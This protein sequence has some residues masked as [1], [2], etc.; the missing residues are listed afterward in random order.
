MA[1]L[2]LN[3]QD[4]EKSRLLALGEKNVRFIAAKSLTQTAQQIQA[5]VKQHL[6]ETF[7][8]RKPNFEKS[9]KIR[10]ATKQNLTAETY[11]MAGFATLQQTGGHRY[12]KNGRL[13]VPKYTDLHQVKANRK[14]D[15]P[16]SFVLRFKSGE[17]VIAHRANGQIR[18]LYHI[19]GLARVPK[20]LQM[21]EIGTDVATTQFKRIFEENLNRTDL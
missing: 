8:L 19:K 5:K 1:I 20:R 3:L 18:I 17:R 15:V 4:S 16:G 11:T 2:Q 7:V 12:A 9:I 21:L 10:S 14:S 13:A 6:H